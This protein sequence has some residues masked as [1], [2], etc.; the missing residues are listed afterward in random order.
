MRRATFIG[1]ILLGGVLVG[2]C[3]NAMLQQARGAAEPR[4]IAPKGPWIPGEQAVMDR[5]KE[6]A[7]SVVYITSIAYQ[8]DWFSLD[9]Q[10]VP[11]GTGSG[12]VWDERGHIVTNFHVVEN[13]QE[14]EVS[15]QGRTPFKARV[16]GAAPDKDLA[17]LR[18]DAPP[19][20][21]R[22]IPVGRSSELQVGQA[23][24]AIGNPFGLDHTL[25]TGV[26]SALGREIQSATRRRISGVI[27]TDAAINPGNSGGPLLDSSGRLIGINTAI[28][29]TSGSSAGIGFAVPV[30]T[31][32]RVVPQLISRGQALR[33]DPGFDPLPEAW[34]AYFE[35]PKGVVVMRVHRGGPAER[36]GLEG[37]SRNGR[38]YVLGDVISAVNGTAVNS[39][40]R[41]MDLLEGESI[42]S[43][44]QLQVIRNGRKISLSMRLQ[45]E[46]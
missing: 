43:T 13:A 32:N 17:V 2:W 21:L 5:F 6:A 44:I 10:A 23:V 36:A 15:F 45:A 20:K 18:L 11:T 39:F 12:F 4:P 46:A 41:L 16:I 38:R 25:T 35:A 28:Q 40:D 8:R 3:G 9:V 26:V 7:S 14:L 31:V 29:S 34:S 27:Q 37:I 1:I 33:P 42:G 24:L 19:A 22:P 30:D